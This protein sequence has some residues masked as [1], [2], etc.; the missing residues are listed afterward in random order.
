MEDKH[1][2]AS[3]IN[4]WFDAIYL[5]NLDRR[6]ER[7]DKALKQLEAHGIDNVLRFPAI[8]GNTLEKHPT[9]NAGQLGCTVSHLLILHHAKDNNFK[10]ILI[11][12]DDIV[13]GDDF[14]QVL[15]QAID[16]LPE[17]W[18]MF[19]MGGNHF[20]GVEN[21]SD[22]LVK[23]KGTL[24]THAI[25]INQTFFDKA[26]ETISPLM[27]VIDVY[28]MVMHEQYACFCTSPKIVFQAEG[29]SDL[30]CRQVNYTSLHN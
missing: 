6:P 30:E 28:Y 4:T 27:H 18:C 5:I 17:D 19:Y 8:D 7:L 24:T 2:P 16:E 13:L 21:Y 14:N 29:Y 12:E 1:M 15:N 9:L 23:L 26:I 11:F 20:K 22:A 3:K 10:R 25:A